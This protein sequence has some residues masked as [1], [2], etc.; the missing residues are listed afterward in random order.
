MSRHYFAKDGSYGDADG[1]VVIDTSNWT[2]QD[3]AS[4]EGAADDMMVV[5][6]LGIYELRKS[7]EFDENPWE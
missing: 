7:S 1:L 4:L 5:I 2:A 3:W 6:A